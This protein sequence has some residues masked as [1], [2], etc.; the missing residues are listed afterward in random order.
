MNKALFTSNSD[1]WETPQEFFEELN[2]EF[3]FTLDACANKDNAK[4]ERYFSEEENGLE[5]SWG[6]GK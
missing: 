4:C 3:H 2:N 6:G 1:I 5:Q